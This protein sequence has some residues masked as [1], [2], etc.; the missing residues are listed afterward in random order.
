M[1]LDLL[2]GKR[3]DFPSEHCTE[4]KMVTRMYMVRT[5]FVHNK[6]QKQNLCVKVINNTDVYTYMK[7]IPRSNDSVFINENIKMHVN[8]R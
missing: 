8:F 1:I 6:I 7:Q 2:S 5:R 4:I 3:V